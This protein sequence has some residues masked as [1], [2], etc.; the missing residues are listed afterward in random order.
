MK[1]CMYME[2][3]ERVCLCVALVTV[4]SVGSMRIR[5]V[6]CGPCRRAKLTPLRRTW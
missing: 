4:A 5:R 1:M 6:L 3:S 2:T